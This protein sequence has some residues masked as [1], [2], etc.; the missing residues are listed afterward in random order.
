M[1]K[2]QTKGPR[3]KE[4]DYQPKSFV[5]HN[6]FDAISQEDDET[7]DAAYGVPGAIGVPADEAAAE[8]PGGTTTRTTTSSSSASAAEHPGASKFATRAKTPA[9]SPSTA[10]TQHPGVGKFASSSSFTRSSSPSTST[11]SPVPTFTQGMQEVTSRASTRSSAPTSTQGMQ[12]VTRHANKVL[13]QMFESAPEACGCGQRAPRCGRTPEG[14]PEV[15]RE[16]QLEDLIKKPSPNPLRRQRAEGKVS[17]QSKGLN[18]VDALQEL[19][20]SGASGQASAASLNLLRGKAAGPQ[21]C[22]FQTPDERGAKPTRDPRTWEVISA[23]VDSG[24]TITAL[25]PGAGKGYPIEESPASREGVEYETA[26]DTTL[27]DLGM[28][29]MAVLTPRARCEGT[30]RRLWTS[31]RAWR[32]CASCARTSTVSC[33]A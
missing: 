23:V 27:P 21:L 9:F 30:S 29:R 13:K 3:R 20:A 12:E 24:A 2:L 6:P 1:Y 10:T 8:R 17:E 18:L 31:P 14:K 25:K 7:S 19:I 32:A 16:V 33:S 4:I 5:H 26:A 22:A 28:K 11:W 15:T